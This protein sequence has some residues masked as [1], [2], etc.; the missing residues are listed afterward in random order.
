MD[1]SRL[2]PAVSSFVFTADVELTTGRSIGLLFRRVTRERPHREP[3]SSALAVLLDYE[4]QC[5]KFAGL[6]NLETLDARA[7]RL[8]RRRKYSLRIMAKAEFFEV[9]LDDVLLLNLVRYQP[10]KGTF[11]LFLEKG[12]GRFSNIRAT[13]L[14]V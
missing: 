13:D 2:W 8:E 11:G 1:D 9:Y 6:K 12:Q 10:E 3:A 4:E 7:R 14:Q 5:V